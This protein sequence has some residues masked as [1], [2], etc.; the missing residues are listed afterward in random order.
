MAN[1]II[2]AVLAILVA[3]LNLS[4]FISACVS[5]GQV[6]KVAKNL[7]SP[8]LEVKNAIVPVFQYFIYVLCILSAV[9]LF[10]VNIAQAIL[11]VP[12]VA[13]RVPKSLALVIS[14]VCCVFTVS[15]SSTFVVAFLSEVGIVEGFEVQDKSSFGFPGLVATH[16]NLIIC[17]I[18]FVIVAFV[19]NVMTIAATVTRAVDLY[20]EESVVSTGKVL[21]QA[22]SKKSGDEFVSPSQ[23]YNIE[24]SV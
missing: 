21:R 5:I 9:I 1:I 20:I 6:N 22:N 18:F 3:A 12:P 11:A 23:D 15:I 8:T 4:L 14:V 17:F 10:L 2:A 7:G 24:S 19:S 13:A 16:A